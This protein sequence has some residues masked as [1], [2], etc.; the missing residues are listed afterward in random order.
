MPAGAN[1]ACRRPRLR[2]EQTLVT[3]TSRDGDRQVDVVETANA[4][5]PFSLSDHP[6]GGL[7]VLGVHFLLE[8]FPTLELAR[9]A[10]EH[11]AAQAA[12]WGTYEARAV[13]CGLCTEDELL[14]M[15][16][17][18]DGDGLPEMACEEGRRERVAFELSEATTWLVFAVWDFAVE[19]A[20]IWR[21]LRDGLRAG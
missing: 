17:E 6:A 15:L 2:V 1:P 20:G 9:Q 11:Y 5:F 21:D 3:Y 16:R 12:R 18:A 10:A 7:G 19:V 13:H 14:E 4:D 8:S